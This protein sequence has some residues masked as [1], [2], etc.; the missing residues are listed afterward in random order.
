M[1]G[2]IIT[3]LSDI[4]NDCPVAIYGA[5]Q[6]GTTFFQVLKE[7]KPGNRI[8]CYIDS[9]KSGWKNGLPIFHLKEFLSSGPAITGMIVLVASIKWREIENV[10]LE[11]NFHSYL[12]IPC[13]F[14][15]LSPLEAL[16]GDKRY[17][18]LDNPRNDILFQKVDRQ[19]YRQ[20]LEKVASLLLHPEERAFYRVLSGDYT[21]YETNLDAITDYY[22]R[23]SFD[24][25]YF[26]FI[27]YSCVSTIIEGGV[28]DGSETVLFRERMKPGGR[29]YGF[30]PNIES[31][32]R[33]PYYER[34]NAASEVKIIPL[35]LW[36]HK[37]KFFLTD[38]CS[39]S[40]IISPQ[41][42]T[43]SSATLLSIE[44]ISIDEFVHEQCVGK[45]DFIKMDIEGAEL[46]ALKGGVETLKR[47]RP[48]LAICIYHK[49]EDF[50][51]IPL[52]LDSILT[53]YQYRLGHYSPGSLETVWY[54]IPEQESQK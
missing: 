4:P 46:D 41:G 49:K 45:V 2:K 32:R 10:L 11:N 8:D 53:N 9:W 43:L 33:G 31:F 3:K 38:Q 19:C 29:I 6:A 44:T 51:Q 17:P 12:I 20:E 1:R 47:D 27:D 52:F 7:C 37:D 48:Q 15:M 13:R 26:D 54:A 42:V 18:P 40:K 28:F 23:S 14:F 5:G 22:Y 25:C 21:G 36:S 35:G 50:F 39:A 30:E 16:Q 34:L 24:A